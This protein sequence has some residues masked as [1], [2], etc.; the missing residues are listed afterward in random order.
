MGTY[1]GSGVITCKPPKFVETGVYI[2][3]ISMD[4]TSFLPQSFEINI[5]KDANIV[6]Q[7]PAIVGQNDLKT[8][9][10]KLV[11]IYLLNS[12]TYITL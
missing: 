8:S 9:M 11:L 4:G 7:I 10:I 2:V 3:T 6:K 12:S 5:Y 1:T